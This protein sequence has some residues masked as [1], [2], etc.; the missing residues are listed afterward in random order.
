[1]V[2]DVVVIGAG[3][4]GLMAA[5]TAAREGKKVLLIEKME[6]A[7][8][9]IRI[10][11]KGRC[12]ITNMRPSEEFLSKVRANREFFAPSFEGFDNEDCFKFFE[13]LGLELEVER[14][15]RVFPSSG[16][17]WDVANALV[18]W[19]EEA[20]VEMWFNSRVEKIKVLSDFISGVS[21]ITKRGFPRNVECKNVIIA[22]GGVSYPGTG[23]TGDGYNFAYE[24]G[25]NI[26]EIRPA[27]VPLESTFPGVLAMQGLMLK[28][29]KV[30]L[31]IDG[32]IASEEFGE[33]EFT[34]KGLGGS[35]ILRISRKAVDALID[36]RRVKI[37]I[38]LKPALSEE[39]LRERIAR[40][41]SMLEPSE[42]MEQLMRK[43]MPKQLV[44]PLAKAIE[45]PFKATVEWFSEENCEKLIAVLKEFVI[46]VSDYRPFEEAVVTAGGVD[47]N[48]VDAN[49]LQSK[50]IKGLY[51]AG[52]VLDLDADTG[53][54]NLQIAFSTGVL[55]GK[56]L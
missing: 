40:E 28:N 10:S 29:V 22:T 25:H 30:K 43:L 18:D 26:E 42:G 32:E 52:E 20:G 19:C 2:Y 47:V 24:L 1:M 31:L 5:G 41:L 16:K 45:A 54:Y 12:N 35:V 50:L 15:E 37:A 33:M 56:L 14:G 48:D 27:L 53:G 49:T 8:R 34:T 3:A 51:F 4:S 11:G 39:I 36:E 55:A 44:S 17:A 13:S 7:G 21:Y 38:D 23:S 9:K 46:P 6:K